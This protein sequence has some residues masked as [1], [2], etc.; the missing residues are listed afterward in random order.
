[1]PTKVANPRTKS[2][3]HSYIQ[4]LANALAHVCSKEE[5]YA[6]IRT[7]KI[8]CGPNQRTLSTK[9]DYR[10]LGLIIA[11]HRRRNGNRPL[12][13]EVLHKSLIEG[14]LERHT[15]TPIH[16][17][18][19]ALTPKDVRSAASAAL[20]IKNEP[21]DFRL[22]RPL[23]AIQYTGRN[24][25]AVQKFCLKQ[26]GAFET[27]NMHPVVEGHKLTKYDWVVSVMGVTFVFSEKEAEYE[28]LK[29]SRNKSTVK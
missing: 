21:H 16:C 19:Q 9:R 24:A 28:F 11:Q 5:C 7:K 26:H 1:V 14:K 12:I 18:T 2:R 23:P 20:S 10:C 17:I 29:V 25:R 27:I 4:S 13:S 15:I 22:R 6:I 3:N 8:D